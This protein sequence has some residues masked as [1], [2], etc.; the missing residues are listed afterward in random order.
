[1]QY[2]MNERRDSNRYSSAMKGSMISLDAQTPSNATEAAYSV[3]RGTLFKDNLLLGKQESTP[4]EV[5]NTPKI[6]NDQTEEIEATL[7]YG[8][9]WIMGVTLFC[10]VL[11]TFSITFHEFDTEDSV[12]TLRYRLG[13][14][15]YMVF[16]FVQ[17]LV[18]I[19]VFMFSIVLYC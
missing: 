14:I 17:T 8:F 3:Q 7:S 13:Q 6:D 18:L 19:G 10:V 9:N 16:F 11:N 1:M 4:S 12:T 5:Q 15:F 2:A